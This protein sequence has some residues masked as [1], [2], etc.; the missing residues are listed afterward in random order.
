MVSLDVSQLLNSLQN[1]FY[2]MAHLGLLTRIH[3]YQGKGGGEL[4][5]D[6]SA[7]L[8]EHIDELASKAKDDGAR[9]LT[10]GAAAPQPPT[11]TKNSAPSNYRQPRV[12][13]LRNRLN[14]LSR[15]FKRRS[16]SVVLQPHLSDQLQRSVRQHLNTSL[17]Q[18]RQGDVTNAKLHANLACNA[19]HELAHYMPN[20]DFM[21]FN[22]Q[23]ST[24]LK[25]FRDRDIFK[26]LTQHLD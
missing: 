2:R 8:S 4:V 24:D 12:Q 7:P 17:R 9:P 26:P 6:I 18:A 10:E 14:G 16:S 20:E 3:S 5:E 15:L 23:I 25:E 13:L 11:E 21:R 19:M 22:V 1:L